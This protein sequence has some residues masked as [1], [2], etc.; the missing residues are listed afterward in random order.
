MYIKN[1]ITKQQYNEV[2]G[3]SRTIK[4]HHCNYKIMSPYLFTY[5]Y[6]LTS[7]AHTHYIAS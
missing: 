3:L 4:K 1:K 6:A 2:K 7:E 5:V